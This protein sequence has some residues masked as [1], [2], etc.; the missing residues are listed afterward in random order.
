MEVLVALLY[1]FFKEK[2]IWK[3]LLIFDWFWLTNKISDVFFFCTEYNNRVRRCGIIAHDTSSFFLL[4]RNE[5]Q[6][7][8]PLKEINQS[9]A[10][11]MKWD[12][13]RHTMQQ[14]NLTTLCFF[15]QQSYIIIVF[16]THLNFTWY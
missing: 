11:N 3:Q 7:I 9:N 12:I 5:K 4:K 8:S 13:K 10:K 2:K 14:L 1:I 6:E 16:L 15:Y